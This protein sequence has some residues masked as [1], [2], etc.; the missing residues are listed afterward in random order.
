MLPDGET[1][2]RRVLLGLAPELVRGELTAGE[3]ANKPFEAAARTPEETD[4]L[5]TAAV[6]SRLHSPRFCPTRGRFPHRRA[7]ENLWWPE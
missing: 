7:A 5:A 1:A 3:V 6:Y 2:G 4:F